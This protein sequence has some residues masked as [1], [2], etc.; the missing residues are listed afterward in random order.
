MFYLYVFIVF[1]Q[2]VIRI[3]RID[4][5]KPSCLIHKFMDDITLKSLVTT[6]MELWSKNNSMKMNF[7]KTKKWFLVSVDLC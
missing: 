2:R 4:D 5:Q 6:L 3:A 7:K 1:L